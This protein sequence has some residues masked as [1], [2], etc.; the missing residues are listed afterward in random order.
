MSSV[1]AVTKAQSIISGLS[2]RDK[3]RIYRL[4]EKEL[5]GSNKGISKD[6]LVMGGAACIRDT[7]IP[8]WM[9][10][11]AKDFG[12]SEAEL[13][14]NYPALSASDLTNAWNYAKG[15]RKEIEKAVL[16]NEADA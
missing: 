11:Q 16:A 15:H 12:V 13:L 7:R 10:V 2:R 9:L 4:L 14:R 6:P 3:S 1:D 5:G 8:V